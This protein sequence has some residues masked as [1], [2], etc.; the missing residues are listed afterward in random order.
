M[1]KSKP[2]LKRTSVEPYSI[3][4]FAIGL[5]VVLSIVLSITSIVS[6]MSNDLSRI[7]TPEVTKT[8]KVSALPKTN[9]TEPQNKP[10]TKPA[11]TTPEAPKVD[12][13][14][15]E[16]KGMWY[17]ADNNECIPKET[18]P[19]PVASVATHTAVAAS[20]SGDCSLVS[21]FSD[22]NQS[23][24][25]NVCMAESGG[26]PNNRNDS[27][28]HPEMGCNGSYGLFQINCGHGMVFDGRAN[29]TIAH[30]M[31]SASGWQPWGATTCRYKVSC[32]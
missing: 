32:Y 21:M 23:V 18:A 3:K 6:A 25:F 19:A 2:K 13:N 17:R 11:E 31:W 7:K 5:L 16:A 20:G 30:S 9:V 10:E 15:C 1:V 29:V 24:A 27:D 4:A 26:N 8:A 28:P 14:G 12:P 22:W